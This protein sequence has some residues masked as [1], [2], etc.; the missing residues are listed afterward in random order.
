MQALRFRKRFK[1]IVLSS[2]LFAGGVS[3]ASFDASLPTHLTSAELTSSRGKN[4]GFQKGSFSCK[5]LAGGDTGV[6]AAPGGGCETC[7]FEEYQD[8]GTNPGRTNP[9]ANNN[10]PL[11]G[12]L[13]KGVWM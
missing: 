7:E 6:C 9:G 11:C 2:G 3:T 8:T 10:T 5:A 1:A 13:Y 4:D 12:S